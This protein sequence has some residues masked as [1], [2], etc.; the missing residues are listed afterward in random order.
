MPLIEVTIVEGRSPEQK[1]ALIR[2]L[3]DAAVETVDV[4]RDAVR[5]CIREIPLAHWGIGGETLSAPRKR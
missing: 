2:R 5:V 4:P 3:T 1:A